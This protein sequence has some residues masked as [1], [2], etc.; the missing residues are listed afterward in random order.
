MEKITYEKI[1]VGKITVGKFVKILT[2]G[3]YL[4]KP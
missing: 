1:T 2:V 3:I 4:S